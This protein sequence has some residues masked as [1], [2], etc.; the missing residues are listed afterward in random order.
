VNRNPRET[1]NP[2]LHKRAIP[3]HIDGKR[4]ALEHSRQVV[5][6]VRRAGSDVL[7]VARGVEEGVRVQR[8]AVA[9]EEEGVDA[10]PE[11]LEGEIAWGEERAA[12]VGVLGVIQL[13]EETRLA[14][15]ELQRAELAG[16]QVDDRCN[17][18]WGHENGIKAVDHAVCAEDVD[19]DDAG[20]EVDRR[21]LERDAHSEA[22]VVAEL[23]GRLEQGGDGVG[24]EDAAGGIEVRAD[25][26]E[27]DVLEDFLGGLLVVLGNL[28]EGRVG[29]GEDG[30]VCLCAV[31]RLDEVGVLVDELGELG[32]VVALVD[33]L[34]VVSRLMVLVLRLAYLVQCPVGLAIM[35][36][37]M[38]SA[39][40]WRAVMRWVVVVLIEVDDT[41]VEGRALKPCIYIDTSMV[42]LAV[43][44]LRLILHLVECPI[45]FAKG[46]V[47][48]ILSIVDD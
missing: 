30:V 1:I 19:G 39:V 7:I 48:D 9:A 40:V 29:G 26:V 15:A 8:L 6:V 32:G 31:E 4:L 3:C 17:V 44:V 13:V 46:I 21:A 11:F 20:V 41:V 33:E 47:N 45:D 35:A 38:G 23:L 36:R 22:L 5:V 43:N 18:W 27:E 14:E 42:D 24:V 25:V 34:N 12:L 28:L 37:M 10:L 16:K 2:D